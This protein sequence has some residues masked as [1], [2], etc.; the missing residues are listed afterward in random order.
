MATY[1]RHV[2]EMSWRWQDMRAMYPKSPANRLSG[3]HRAKILPRRGPF[4]CTDPSNHA[5]RANLAIRRRRT[6]RA[7]ATS[8]PPRAPSGPKGSSRASECLNA[9]RCPC[10]R[11]VMPSAGLMGTQAL[12][13]R[14]PRSRGTG[15]HSSRHP[16]P[17]R[18]PAA[19]APQALATP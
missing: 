7:P 5:R 19:P 2:S 13:H 15:P 4:R 9:P 1:R 14:G 8:A 11:V 18:R 10:L 17:H 6:A 12:R 16:A 3:M